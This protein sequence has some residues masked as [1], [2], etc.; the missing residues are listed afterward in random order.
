MSHDGP[1]RWRMSPAT[2]NAPVS[3]NKS[4]N[5]VS[6]NR[7]EPCLLEK[8]Y[9][10]FLGPHYQDAL[11][12]ERAQWLSVTHKTFDQGK[13]GFNDRLSFIGIV[14]PFLLSHLH[15][16]FVVPCAFIDL[17]CVIDFRQ[18]DCQP[19]REPFHFGYPHHQFHVDGRCSWSRRL[20]TPGPQWAAILDFS[21]P[22]IAAPQEQS[23][24]PGLSIWIA[25]H[26]PVD[27][28]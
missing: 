15:W 10:N 9:H 12:S 23:C 20:L 1:P 17:T 25:A 7:F 26:Y 22:N 19:P 11:P 2:L 13:Q 14:Q 16:Y 4:K 8:A 21:P 6:T 5:P 24:T 28:S 27:A 18:T 3:T